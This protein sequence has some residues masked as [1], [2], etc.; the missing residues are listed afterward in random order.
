M[1]SLLSPISIQFTEAMKLSETSLLK[2]LKCRM[3]PMKELLFVKMSSISKAIGEMRDFATK[4]M[5]V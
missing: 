3:M 1:I 5:S 2:K 4:W